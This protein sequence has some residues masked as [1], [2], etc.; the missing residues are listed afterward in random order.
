MMDDML[1]NLKGISPTKL[2]WSTLNSLAGIN[3]NTIT[4]FSVA[5]K[6]HVKVVNWLSGTD[7]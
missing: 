7:L 3:L 2:L 6:R 1:A 4:V 5:A